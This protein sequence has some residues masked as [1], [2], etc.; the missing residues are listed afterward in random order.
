MFILN[1]VIMYKYFLNAFLYI[2]ISVSWWPIMVH[3]FDILP[4]WKC[5][6]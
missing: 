2:D 3:L 6:K 4:N 5:R 1:F